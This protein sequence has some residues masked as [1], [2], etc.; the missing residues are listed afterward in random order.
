MKNLKFISF[1]IF[2]F[3]FMLSCQKDASQNFSLNIPENINLID[4][5]IIKLDQQI[6]KLTIDV[7]LEVYNRWGVLVHKSSSTSD[8]FQLFQ[9]DLGEKERNGQLYY[10]L[11]YYLKSTGEIVKKTGK[12][13]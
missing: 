10:F 5:E 11:T 12:I 1:Q 9:S 4:H 6:N 8:I 3:L 13:K 7:K 2:A